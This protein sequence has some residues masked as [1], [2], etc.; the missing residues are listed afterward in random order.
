MAGSVGDAPGLL[1][2]QLKA[3]KHSWKDALKVLKHSRKDALKAL[4]C[5]RKD[6]LNKSV[7]VHFSFSFFPHPFPPEKFF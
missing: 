6:A 3:L 1:P 7:G 5:N 4:K 2:G